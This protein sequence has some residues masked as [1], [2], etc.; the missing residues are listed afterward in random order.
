MTDDT[1]RAKFEQWLK[2]HLDPARTASGKRSKSRSVPQYE[3]TARLKLLLGAPIVSPAEDFRAG[4]KVPY[5]IKQ[6][7]RELVEIWEPEEILRT[8]R[9]QWLYRDLG[10]GLRFFERHGTA[11]DGGR[12]DRWADAVLSRLNRIY[13]TDAPPKGEAAELI[14]EARAH[15]P[16][17]GEPQSAKS[18]RSVA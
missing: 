1:L 4:E 7:I 6:A 3:G 10:A 17:F 11:P 14:S 5:R 18:E 9:D 8:R 15:R 13:Q 16:I 12:I 2:E